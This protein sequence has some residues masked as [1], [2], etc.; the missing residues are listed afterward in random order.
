VKPGADRP[1]PVSRQIPLGVA[2][3]FGALLVAAG[4]VV[5][6]TL[7]GWLPGKLSDHTPPAILW[8]CGL[9]FF[10]VGGALL[11]L[12]V[13]PRISGA[14]ALAALLAFTA[15]FNWIA[16]GPGERHFTK[17]SRT[18]GSTTTVTRQQPATAT[19]GRVV[20]G[21]FAG[22]LDLLLVFGLYK[23]FTFRRGPGR[24]GDGA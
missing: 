14:C 22:G 12:H 6:A 4:A 16:F 8:L 3:G 5:F 15:L 1:L 11:L 9:L 13:L 18:G 10:S 17:S 2:L 23:S 21:L 19:E 20:F 7:L 24:P